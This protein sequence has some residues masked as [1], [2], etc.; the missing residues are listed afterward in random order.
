MQCCVYCVI[1]MHIRRARYPIGGCRSC[2]ISR[3]LFTRNSLLSLPSL[4]PSLSTPC[5]Q[6]CS[7]VYVY[8]IL[9][10]TPSYSYTV[11]QALPDLSI[12]RDPGS[13]KPGSSGFNMFFSAILGCCRSG[14]TPFSPYS[15]S[16]LSMSEPHRDFSA[17]GNM[18]AS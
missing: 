4:P 18:K 16:Y 15:G 14:W 5:I 2:M 6:P 11:M 1:A 17:R 3:G 10:K 9:L 13:S 8:R 12:S 7:S